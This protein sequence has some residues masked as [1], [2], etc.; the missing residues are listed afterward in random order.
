MVEVKPSA[1]LLLT[2]DRRYVEF[3]A[4]QTTRLC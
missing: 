2:T 1:G 3:H 4:N